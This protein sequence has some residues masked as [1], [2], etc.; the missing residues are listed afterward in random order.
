MLLDTQFDTDS[1]DGNSKY[2]GL[3]GLIPSLQ[4]LYTFLVK[5]LSYSN[6]AYGYSNKRVM[7]RTGFIGTGF[8]TIDYDKIS[9]IELKVNLIE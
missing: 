6:T 8:K 2:F 3:F 4:G 5:L 7:M 1:A 9:D